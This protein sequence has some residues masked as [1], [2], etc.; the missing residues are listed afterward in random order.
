M[1][2]AAPSVFKLIRNILGDELHTATFERITNAVESHYQ[3]KPSEIV[4][5]YRFNTRTRNS[6]ET[7]TGYVAA[8]RDI[9]QDCNYGDTLKEMIRDRL[10]CG[11]NHEGIQ[12]KL[13]AE[14]SL[15]FDKAYALA[16]SIELAAAERDSKDLRNPP[17]PQLVQYQASGNPPKLDAVTCYRCGGT[18][19]GHGMQTYHS[20]Q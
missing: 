4:R 15:D 11:I 8:L 1:S 6:G 10:V 16:L 19:L 14:K 17:T 9:A 5:R 20:M 7:V 3:P 12:R 18:S 2:N 13:L